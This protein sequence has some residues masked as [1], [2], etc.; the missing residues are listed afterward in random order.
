MAAHGQLDIAAE[1]WQ[2][3]S[4]VS[5]EYAAHPHHSKER[6]TPTENDIFNKTISN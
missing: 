2:R 4:S 1:P 3:W 6:L 5:E